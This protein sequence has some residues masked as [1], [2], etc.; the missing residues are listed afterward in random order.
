MA[1]QAQLQT[2][3]AFG[4]SPPRDECVSVGPERKL[5]PIIWWRSYYSSSS[6][7]G[8]ALFVCRMHAETSGNEKP[9]V[10]FLQ[11]SRQTNE[12]GQADSNITLPWI[13]VLPR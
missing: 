9:L 4:R 3:Q 8:P 13:L 7:E 6:V 12:Y 10:N 5:T 11:Q 1:F 2:G